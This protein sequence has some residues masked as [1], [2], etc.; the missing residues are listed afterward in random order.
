MVI[1][2]KPKSYTCLN[3]IALAYPFGF[4]GLTCCQSSD[5]DHQKLLSD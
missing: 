4:V 1:E 3:P 5:L 2:I